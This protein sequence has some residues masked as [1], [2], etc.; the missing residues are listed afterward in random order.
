MMKEIN[1]DLKVLVCSGYSLDRKF[2]E[3]S[4]G[5]AVDILHKPFDMNTFRERLD[6]FMSP[7][8]ESPPVPE[9]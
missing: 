2:L 5:S 1:P 8:R 7:G 6:R 9:I 4:R 3:L